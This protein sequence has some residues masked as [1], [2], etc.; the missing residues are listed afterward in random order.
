M[1]KSERTAEGRAV[2]K[3]LAP[4]LLAVVHEAVEK[5]D[6]PDNHYVAPLLTGDAVAVWTCPEVPYEGHDNRGSTSLILALARLA[7]GYIAEGLD[8]SAR[9]C[10]WLQ[11]KLR[12]G[13]LQVISK[14]HLETVG[15]YEVW[16]L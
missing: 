13:S 3:T 8:I 2:I 4:C 1:I 15:P 5:W 10:F 14:H 12:A 9:D 7:G 6:H 16:T 11:A